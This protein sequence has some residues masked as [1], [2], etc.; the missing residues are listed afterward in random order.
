M[1]VHQHAFQKTST[2][3]SN[4]VNRGSF[5]PEFTLACLYIQQIQMQT[6]FKK[7]HMIA[8]GQKGYSGT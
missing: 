6:L 8:T 4:H 2:G 5:A 7:T 3:L 1:S